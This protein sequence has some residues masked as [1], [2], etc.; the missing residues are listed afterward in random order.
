MEVTQRQMDILR[1]AVKIIA[2]QGFRE[3]TTKNMAKELN[4]TEAALYRH[5]KSKNHI[6]Q[7]LLNYF[8]EISAD[9]LN[10]INEKQVSPW[11]KVELFI[12][13]R[14]QFFKDDP[15]LSIVLFSEEL[16]KNDPSLQEQLRNIMYQHRDSMTDLIRQAQAQNEIKTPI[17]ASQLYIIMIGSMRHIITQWNV[18]TRNNDLIKEGNKLL[19]TIRTLFDFNN[20]HK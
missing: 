3:L 1:A 15:D 11:Q 8:M 16:Y 18:G 7:T 10:S 19:S 17:E 4:L 5:F 12:S 20:S 9:F 13:N 6:L 14:L 2:N